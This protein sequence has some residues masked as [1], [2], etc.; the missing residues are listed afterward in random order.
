[1]GAAS[2][3]G[4]IRAWWRAGFRDADYHWGRRQ[5][6]RRV[7]R[8]TLRGRQQDAANAAKRGCVRTCAHA[9]A[10]SPPLGPHPHPT[11]RRLGGPVAR[12]PPLGRARPA[13]RPCRV[14]RRVQ[15]AVHVPQ[16]RVGVARTACWRA[17]ARAR[18]LRCSTRRRAVAAPNMLRFLGIR[19]AERTSHASGRAPISARLQ[20]QIGEMQLAARGPH[21]PGFGANCR[22]PVFATTANSLLYC[23]V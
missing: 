14:R 3:S 12:L 6:R 11:A 15:P 21:D 20:I 19:P 9:R 5:R 10:L 18:G 16:R 7:C 13:G 1:M 2:A 23:D 22:R 17:L 4:R 8:D